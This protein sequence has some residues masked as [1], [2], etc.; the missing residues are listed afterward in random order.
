MYIPI[1]SCLPSTTSFI[2]P[3]CNMWYTCCLDNS[4]L[5]NSLFHCI[6]LFKSI[7]LFC[8]TDNILRTIPHVQPEWW[9]IWQSNINTAKRCYGSEWCYVVCGLVRI[10]HHKDTCSKGIGQHRPISSINY[11]TLKIEHIQLRNHQTCT[12]NNHNHSF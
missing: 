11:S 4:Q 5:D 2:L 10:K 7:T 9:N 1:Q 12:S 3:W 8:G 6:T